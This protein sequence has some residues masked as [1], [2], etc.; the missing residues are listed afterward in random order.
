[1]QHLVTCHTPAV[2]DGSV[3]VSLESAWLS[4][5]V[6]TSLNFTTVPCVASV[7]VTGE[8]GPPGDGT[9]VESA[10]RQKNNRRKSSTLGLVMGYAEDTIS[11]KLPPSPIHTRTHS[12]GMLSTVVFG[13]KGM[14]RHLIPLLGL[15]A[16]QTSQQLG[17]RGRARPPPVLSVELHDC[18]HSCP[19]VV[20]FH[21][22][23]LSHLQ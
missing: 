7:E 6:G 11:C 13:Y 23:S 20:I 8:A 5:A 4:Q 22:A 17:D 1:M 12:L 18:P 16:W 19:T 21:I 9:D 3:C 15:R 2:T 14:H 10:P